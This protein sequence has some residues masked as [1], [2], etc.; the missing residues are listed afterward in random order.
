MKLRKDRAVKAKPPF[1]RKTAL[2]GEVKHIKQKEM[3]LKVY[4]RMYVCMY[5]RTISP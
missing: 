5:M 4:G 3:V 2:D 1:Q